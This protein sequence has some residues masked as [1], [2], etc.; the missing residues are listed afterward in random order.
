MI[1]VGWPKPT[2]LN[3]RKEKD[4]AGHIATFSWDK[5]SDSELAALDPSGGGY[6]NIFWRVMINE[7]TYLV[8]NNPIFSYR[9]PLGCCKVCVKVST[10]YDLSETS[11][12]YTDIA[13]SEY[14]EETCV[15]CDPDIYCENVRAIGNKVSTQNYG[16]ANM[17]YA[18]AI[19]IGG[20][21]AFR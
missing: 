9:I 19:T 10:I 6:Y 16:S 15:D 21:N 3:V 11:Y 13:T 14:C 7:Q 1:S 18:R 12:T 4:G 2:G 20:A 5:I 8:Y 17:R